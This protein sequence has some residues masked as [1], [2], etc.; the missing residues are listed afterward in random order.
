M[1]RILLA[2]AALAVAFMT[3]GCATGSGKTSK[4]TDGRTGTD[5][6]PYRSVPTVILCDDCRYD[7]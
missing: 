1:R 5:A 2:L 3:I 4:R 7:R 6:S